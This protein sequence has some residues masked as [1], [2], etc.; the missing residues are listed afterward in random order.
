VQSR[1]FRQS[2][3][4]CQQVSAD[5]CVLCKVI[6]RDD[7]RNASSGRHC[8]H[9]ISSCYILAYIRSADG[10]QRYFIPPFLT[11]SRVARQVVLAMSATV[12]RAP[13]VLL[14]S[15]SPNLMGV[16]FVQIC[17]A[18]TWFIANTVDRRSRPSLHSMFADCPHFFLVYCYV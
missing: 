1:S 9:K 6:V 8:A 4:E 5:N 10:E 18:W 2:V 17:H 15:M 11:C 3:R 12:C 13:P 16:I 14:C 7:G